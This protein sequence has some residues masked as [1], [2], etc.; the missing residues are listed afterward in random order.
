MES[1]AVTVIIAVKKASES[2]LES[3]PIAAESM[4]SSTLAVTVIKEDGSQTRSTL[5]A[6]DSKPS[7]VPAVAAVKKTVESHDLA[8]TGD[9]TSGSTVRS[10]GSPSVAVDPSN[11]G[12]SGGETQLTASSPQ[13]ISA[14]GDDVEKGSS[15]RGSWIQD[16][17]L[18]RVKILQV[19]LRPWSLLSVVRRGFFCFASTC[20]H[21]S[22][23]D[24]PAPLDFLD[25]ASVG[26]TSG[27][28]C[29][30]LAC[31]QMFGR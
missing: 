26:L 21:S 4:P 25:G 23:T 12:D 2:R 22:S 15:S 1:S 28:G 31:L 5:I 6:T 17:R 10:S 9:H 27:S 20:S 19:V 11:P 18:N 24:S 29:K 13:D 8:A 7:G 14:P 16:L 30:S 3:D